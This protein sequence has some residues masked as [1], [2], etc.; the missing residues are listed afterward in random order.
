MPAAISCVIKLKKHLHFDVVSKDL[1][2]F[3]VRLYYLAEFKIAI[4]PSIGE[5]S[6]SLKYGNV[7]ILDNT[8]TT[9]R[10]IQNSFESIYLP[11]QNLVYSLYEQMNE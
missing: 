2:S 7:P 11:I 4:Q 8:T 3:W 5:N 10:I 1:I 6:F 9:I